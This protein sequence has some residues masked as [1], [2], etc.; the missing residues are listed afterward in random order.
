MSDKSQPPLP[1]H[2]EE[3]IRSIAQLHEEHHGA[4][5]PQQRVIDRLTALLGR[6]R[7]IG[8]LGL[9][10][11]GWI[12]GNL[13]LAAIG[14]A[15]L[16]PPPFS[17]LTGVG[18]IVSLFMVVLILGAQRHEEQIAQHR[19]LLTL[20]LAI[21]S[22]QKTAKVIQLL[23]E[24]RRDNPMIHDRVDHEANAMAQPSNPQS[25]LDA[26]RETHVAASDTMSARR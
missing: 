13:F 9:A 7:F 17:W 18:T 11:L 16:D 1:E 24:V 4:A 14:R 20:E 21:L 19:E 8:L 5:S 15:P 22:E 6:P 26:I 10:I 2:I 12:G 25:V 23:E 3:T